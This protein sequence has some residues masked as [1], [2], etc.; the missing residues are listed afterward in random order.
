MRFWLR[1]SGGRSGA[2]G[3][4][5]RAGG[6]FQPGAQIRDQIHGVLDADRHAQQSL[7]NARRE[8]R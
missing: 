3:G 6:T 8:P 2:R 7:P 1:F 5:R 4:V